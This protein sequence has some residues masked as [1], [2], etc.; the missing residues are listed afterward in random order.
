MLMSKACYHPSAAVSLWQGMQLGDDVP[1]ILSTHP[2]HE[3]RVENLKKLVHKAEQLMMDSDCRQV[4]GS[5][6]RRMAIS[7]NS[8]ISLVKTIA[9]RQ[10]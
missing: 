6:C 5:S 1:E 4:F 2:H 9:F 3:T 10:E 8:V 7:A